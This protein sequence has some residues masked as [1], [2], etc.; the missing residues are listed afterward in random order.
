[1]PISSPDS[2]VIYTFIYK[3]KAW[4][5]VPVT[6]LTLRG[7]RIALFVETSN[8]KASRRYVYTTPYITLII[9]TKITKEY[10]NIPTEA[11]TV[12]LFLT[13]IKNL[14]DS[15]ESKPKRQV[16]AF[17]KCHHP[18]TTP[19]GVSDSAKLVQTTRKSKSYLQNIVNIAYS[20]HP[21]TPFL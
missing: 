8:A 10:E 7:S 17:P 14:R 20:V 2:A 3:R 15:N 16:N 12:A 13:N 11:F 19:V 9:T 21:C 1:M 6:R 4:E 18:P 5:P